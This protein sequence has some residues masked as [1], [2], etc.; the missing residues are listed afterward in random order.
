MT[1]GMEFRAAVAVLQLLRQP[2][3][4][5]EIAASRGVSVKTARRWAGFAT[6]AGDSGSMARFGAETHLA[7]SISFPYRHAQLAGGHQ[8][9]P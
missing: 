9:T 8:E 7:Q 5:Y 6:G 4:V 3:T 2:R 1:H